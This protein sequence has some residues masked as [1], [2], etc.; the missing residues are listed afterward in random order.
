MK[1]LR[2]AL[3]L[4]CLLLLS[5]TAVF[6]QN[7]AG[8][9]SGTVTDA[10]GGAIKG[11]KVVAHQDATGREFT[12]VS[13]GEGLYAFPNLDVGVYTLVVEQSGFK[14]LTQQ[15]VVIAIS[16]VTVANLKLE[17]GDV[18]QTVTVNAGVTQLQTVTTEIG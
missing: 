1:T 7:S 4:C 3:S 2:L 6:S 13:T 15:N 16:N 11:A 8:S 5:A 9:L 18:A 14:R 12:T 10:N 17:G